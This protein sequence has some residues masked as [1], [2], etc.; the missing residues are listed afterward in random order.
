MI[1]G[2]TE[3]RII[4]LQPSVGTTSIPRIIISMEPSIQNICH[5]N[6]VHAWRSE[7]MTSHITQVTQVSKRVLAGPSV[8]K[9]TQILMFQTDEPSRVKRTESRTAC[10]RARFSV[11]DC[12]SPRYA[13]V[14]CYAD[15]AIVFSRFWPVF[16][17]FQSNIHIWPNLSCSPP[18]LISPTA[19]KP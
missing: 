19:I 15:D 16:E 18:A 5:T 17:A 10:R 1:L 14:H 4:H 13:A 3:I 6:R 12:S 9:K 8:E 2:V 7:L 11:K